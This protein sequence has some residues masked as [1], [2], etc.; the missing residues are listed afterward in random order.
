MQYFNINLEF[1]HQLMHNTITNYADNLKKGYVCVVDG[2]IL[3]IAQKQSSYLEILNASTINTCDG[4]AIAMLVRLIHKHKVSPLTGP[5][6]FSY[7][8][9]QR[10]YKQLLLGGME[11]TSKKVKNKLSAKGI[12]NSHLEIMP[13]PFLSPDQFDYPAIAEKINIMKPN[14]IWVSLGAPKQEIFMSRLLPYLNQGLMFGI[15]AAFKFY[16]GMVRQPNFSIG[17]LRFVWFA[18]FLTE[19]KKMT[20]RIVKIL[21]ILPKLIVNEIRK[22]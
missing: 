12:D 3:R 8:I 13:L 11:E 6:L 15:G 7:Y 17:K 4:S 5:D 19:P 21:V 9:E 20:T 18:R 14:L 10:H 16:T 22:G 1:D 2:N